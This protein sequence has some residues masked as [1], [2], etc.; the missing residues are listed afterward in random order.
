MK[1]WWIKFGCF[2]TGYNYQIMS[3]SSEVSV[4]V[5]KRYTS[6]LII[7]CLLWMFV[8]YCFANRYLHLG[9]LG[10]CI[11]A[12]CFVTIII[13]IERQIILLN[14]VSGWIKNARIFIAI[15]MALIGSLIIDQIIFKDDIE[16][17]K[18]TS[19]Q[20]RVDKA[21]VS[22][23]AELRNQI[24]NFDTEISIKESE[25][26]NLINDV[27]KN[28][29]IKVFSSQSSIRKETNTK[30]D[31]STKEKI[32][33]E[34]SSPITSTTSSNVP[35]PKISLIAPL[36]ENIKNLRTQK[37]EKESL[38][39]NIRP[40]VEKDVKQKVGLLDELEVMWSLIFR[41]WVSGIVY[42]IF[43]LFLGMLEILVL[44]SKINEK[45]EENDYDKTIRH[46]SILLSRKLDLFAEMSE[47]KENKSFKS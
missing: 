4:R 5:V 27:E 39:L 44:V 46:H 32:I 7:V 41:S 42:L 40:E 31:S 20:K 6:A 34:I 35:N 47:K 11:S 13:Q 17:E 26:L 18:I 37:S 21:S 25:R 33:S 28:P 19:I 16:L 12:L 8:G 23:S 2:L 36:E 43:F 29:T 14:K 38:L 15:L 30:I 22:K 3:N 1:N 9:I 10:S 45:G 24:A